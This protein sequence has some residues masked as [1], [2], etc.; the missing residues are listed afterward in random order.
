MDLV[1]SNPYQIPNLPVSTQ[2]GAAYYLNRFIY[3]AN[4][5]YIIT[6][7]ECIDITEHIGGYQ[8]IEIHFKT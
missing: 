3:I 4:V 2:K 8:F 1:W 5:P 6:E 7:K